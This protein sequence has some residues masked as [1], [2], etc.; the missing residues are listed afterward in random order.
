M[1]DEETERAERLAEYGR[2]EEARLHA[3]FDRLFK[4]LEDDVA[5]V[6][7]QLRQ[8]EAKPSVKPERNGNDNFERIL[9]D[10]PW[11]Q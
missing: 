6:N 3:M 7:E 11:V 5:R 8:E 4:P 2:Q 10:F 9:Q 1:S